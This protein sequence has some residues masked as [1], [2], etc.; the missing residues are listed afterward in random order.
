M[1]DEYAS[2]RDTYIKYR[3]AH[4]AQFGTQTNAIWD[5]IPEMSKVSGYSFYALS[6]VLARISIDLILQA[7]IAIYKKCD[8]G[9]VDVLARPR[10]LVCRC[11]ALSL[12]CWRGQIAHPAGTGGD[13]SMQPGV[14][15]HFDRILLSSSVFSAI[16]RKPSP[17]PIPHTHPPVY[18]F[19]WMLLGNI[20]IAS[21]LQ[22]LLDHGDNPRFLVPLQSLVVL[23]VAA[24][25]Y[26]IADHKSSYL[27]QA[28]TQP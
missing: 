17:L 7:S 11:P 14:Y 2:L 18:A 5:A 16:R 24:L 12:A 19:L 4:I 9:L 10:L 27:I 25:L 8:L 15:L 1:P 6:R 3:D 23:W 20:W 22:T 28:S 21:I 26:Q 13:L